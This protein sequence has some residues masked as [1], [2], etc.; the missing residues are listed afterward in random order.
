VG[1]FKETVKGISWMGSLRGMTR[2]VGFI[3][4]AILARLLAPTQFGVFGIASLVLAFLEITF[5]TG[6]NV[7]LIQEEGKL[8]DYLDTAWVVSILRGFLISLTILLFSPLI[9]SFFNSPDSFRILLLI[10]TVPFVKGFINPA[11]VK[12]LKDLEFKKEFL[13]RFVIF[14]VDASVSIATAFITKSA[15]SL[16]WG[17]LAGGITEVV[18]SFFILP[19]PKLNFEKEKIKKVVDRG[20]WVTFYGVFNYLFEHGDDIVVGKLMNTSSLGIYQMAYKISSLPISEVTDVIVK[21]TLPV[22]VK[23]SFDKKRLKRAF[24]KTLFTV[25]LAVFPMG[26]VLYLFPKEVIRIVLGEKWIEA[27]AVL[28]LLALFGVLRAIMLSGYTIFLAVKKQEYVTIMTLVGILGLGITIIPLVN[29]FGI[30]GA[31]LSA[32]IATIISFPVFIYLLFRTFNEVKN[33]GTK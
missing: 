19:R 1:Y 6:I 27:Y 32:L 9:S 18:L 14:T 15:V 13:F 10:S 8:E 29:K 23:I 2:I 12:F 28:K 16:V 31:G 17:I 3:K 11:V 7:F 30:Y 5:D 26:L 20:K 21:V 24:F 22:Y 4:I 25:S 33:N